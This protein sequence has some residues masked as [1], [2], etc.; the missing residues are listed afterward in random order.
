MA[1]YQNLNTTVPTSECIA[2]CIVHHEG[3][4][5]DHERRTNDVIKMDYPLWLVDLENNEPGDENVELVE[6]LLDMKENVG[7]RR[8]VDKEGVF[9]DMSIKDSFLNIWKQASFLSLPHG[10]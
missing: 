6:M 8:R 3:L 2:A 7:L 4:Y 10:W 5:V 9:A 1:S